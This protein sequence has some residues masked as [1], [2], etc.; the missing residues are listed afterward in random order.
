MNRLTRQTTTSGIAYHHSGSGPIII[1]IHGVG[2]RAESWATQITA[3]QTEFQLLVPDLPEHGDSVA[4]SADFE[5]VSLTHYV[6]QLADFIYGLT[7]ENIVLCGHSLGALIAIELAAKMPQQI[8]G[9][10]ALNTIF[11]RTDEALKAV[12]G[13]AQSLHQSDSVIG[14]E[15]TL[16]RWFGDP[17]SNANL[18]H[19]SQC[20]SWLEANSVLGYAKAYKAFAYE[21]GANRESLAKLNCP[22][23]FMTGE[24]DP[25]S[26]PHMSIALADFTNSRGQQARSMVVPNSGHMMP[27]THSALVCEQI[28]TLAN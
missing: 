21:S 9:L 16:K 14:V 25:N 6:D 15:Q 26:T 3:L 20:K 17:P 1:F 28:K 10:L 8:I 7:S 23:I 18:V 13:R 27:L 5:A 24:N 12:Q 19:V 4:L 11:D 2:L 22:S